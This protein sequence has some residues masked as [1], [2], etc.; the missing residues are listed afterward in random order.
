MYPEYMMK[1]IKMVEKTRN[2]RLDIAKKHG[3]EVFP[4]YD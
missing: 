1:S 4:W 3:K 2:K